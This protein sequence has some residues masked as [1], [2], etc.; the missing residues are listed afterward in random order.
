MKNNRDWVDYANLASNVAQNFQLGSINSNL[1][2]MK[3]AQQVANRALGELAYNESAKS[4]KAE[5]QKQIRNV[6]WQGLQSLE[7]LKKMAGD[8]P[9]QLA[10]RLNALTPPPNA[11]DLCNDWEDK[12]RM[13]ELKIQES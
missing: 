7:Q 9:V 12:K 10:I 8:N 2:D 1:K 6:I 13:Q 5:S 4:I 3:E 11:A